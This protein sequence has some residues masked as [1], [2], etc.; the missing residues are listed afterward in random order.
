MWF[1]L[2]LGVAL[3]VAALFLNP[4]VVYVGAALV[5]LG[6]YFGLPQD[7][8]LIYLMFILGISLLVVELYVPD[9]GII[10]LLGFIATIIALYFRIGDPI[11]LLLIS[12]ASLG[13]A[14]LVAVILM[15][16]GKTLNISPAF[17]LRTTMNKESGYSSE[18]DLSYLLDQV[19]I[20]VTDLRPV[21]R[22][23]FEDKL[24]DVISIEEMIPQN[25][26]IY[27]ERVQ[28][29]KV[30]VRKGENNV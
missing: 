11:D 7:N 5:S 16:M 2:L 17:I 20:T 29:S 25:V 12:L 3:L 10:G 26:A 27:V 24:Y 28:G 22:A 21:G 13:V 6:F 14:V 19:G 15:R 8:I 4:K 30:Y 18:K 1:F 9:F 23:K